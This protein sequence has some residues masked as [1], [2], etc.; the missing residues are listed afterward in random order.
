VTAGK[1][2]SNGDAEAGV[3]PVELRLGGKVR[4]FRLDFNA[5]I[6]SERATGLNLLDPNVWAKVNSEQLATIVWN[7]VKWNEPDLTLEQVGGWLS[8]ANA[9]DAVGALTQSSG[10]VPK[11]EPRPATSGS[12]DGPSP[13]TT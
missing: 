13:A 9:G 4:L 2:R 12:S 7:A 5:M 8:I 11:A 3:R 6:A 10:A 1:R